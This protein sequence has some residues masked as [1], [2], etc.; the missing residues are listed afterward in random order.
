[1][2]EKLRA[3]YQALVEAIQLNVPPGR[4]RE[5]ALERLDESMLWALHAERGVS[6]MT[7]P[8]GV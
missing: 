2:N 7:G 5:L 6:I 1:M 8:F 3:A 4:E